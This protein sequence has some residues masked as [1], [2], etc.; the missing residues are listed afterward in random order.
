MAG[1]ELPV[2]EVDIAL[3]ASATRVT[4]NN[5]R[6]ARFWWSSWLNGNTPAL[7]FPLLF[8]HS[9]RKN[10]T[11]AEAMLEEQ[12]IQ[13]I[14]HDLTVHLLDEF[15]RMWG[16]IDEVNFDANNLES[17]TIIWTRTASGEYS[18][19][20]A[21]DMQFEGGLLSLFPKMVWKVQVFYVAYV[22]EQGVDS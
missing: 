18:A 4:V 20:S 15:V 3:F 8:K 16:L 17:D 21:Y 7:L 1:M 9:K 12:W 19:K 11:V 5:G 6:T 22:T 2:D 13:D 14:S 10:R